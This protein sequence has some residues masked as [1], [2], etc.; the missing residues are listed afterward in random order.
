G[1]GRTTEA[2]DQLVEARR[3]APLS[4]TLQG[5]YG[6]TLH[7]AGRDAEA[8]RVFEQLHRVDRGWGG[9]LVGLCRVHT[10]VGNFAE[11]LRTCG[12]VR[13]RGTEQ[14]AFVEAQLVTIAA[15]QQRREDATARVQRL[16]QQATTAPLG[17]QA[18][19][20]FF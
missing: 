10:A 3:L 11:A 8:L 18:D 12:E 9:A 5:Y 7:Y 14:Q 16:A 13:Q 19:L 17:H 1:R 15:G 20:A 2:L 6:M 4:S